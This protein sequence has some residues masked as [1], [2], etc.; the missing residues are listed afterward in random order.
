MSEAI[1]KQSAYFILKIYLITKKKL[2][3]Y[4]KDLIMT[5]VDGLKETKE[6]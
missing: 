1:E 4:L 2:K 6:K 3:L 5:K